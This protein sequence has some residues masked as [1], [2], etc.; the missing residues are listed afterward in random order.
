MFQWLKW[1]KVFKSALSKFCGR[2]PL[3]KLKRYG[4]LFK[5]SLPQILLGLFL[6]TLSQMSVEWPIILCNSFRTQL[7]KK[8]LFVL[9]GHYVHF[10][11]MKNKSNLCSSTGTSNEG[12][13][14]EWSCSGIASCPCNNPESVGANSFSHSSSSWSAVNATE[15]GADF[16]FLRFGIFFLLCNKWHIWLNFTVSLTVTDINRSYYW[17][18]TKSEKYAVSTPHTSSWHQMPNS[19]DRLLLT[20]T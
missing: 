9:K 14:G 11:W 7:I 10:C 20:K 12:S 5:S 8:K 2:Q 18:L 3:Q 15:G 16:F 19:I 17:T 13:N 1:D 6:N 4:L